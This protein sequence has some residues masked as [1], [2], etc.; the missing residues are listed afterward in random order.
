MVITGLQA[1]HLEEAAAL[2]AAR[3]RALRRGVP[4]LPPRYEET[5]TIAGMLGDLGEAAGVA[6][7][8]A[9]RLV[10][11]LAGFVLPDLL[12][13]RSFYSPE[14][15]N[16]TQPGNSRRIYE[17][18]YQQAA[19]QWLAAGCAVHAVTLMVN[20]REGVEGWQWLGFGLSNVD[21]VRDLSPLPGSRA[22]AGVR[23]AGRKD[24]GEVTALGRALEQHMAAPPAFWI[25]EVEDYCAWLEQPDHIAWL[26]YE[27]G[28]AVGCLGLEL[29]HAGGCAI[30][31]D[32]KTTGIVLAYT[33]QEVRCRGITGT[34]V[35][36][37]LA[38]ARERG[39]ERC[40][41]DWE[42]MNPP[43]N[44]FWSKRFDPVCYSLIRHIDERLV[45]RG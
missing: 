44:R 24:A 8:Q 12:G 37:A 23:Q 31:Q 1:E 21:G 38:W 14:W 29:G 3:Y 26:A 15:A 30:V 41:A 35:N 43:A 42:A 36:H 10:G 32:E 13:Q 2:V 19:A 18:M 17:A 40:A 7:W 27:G 22:D 9:G 39:Y 6:A 28:E 20:D 33:R 25:H 45:A 16:G 4:H 34:L 5:D 11:F